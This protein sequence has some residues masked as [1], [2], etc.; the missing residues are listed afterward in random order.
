MLA[1]KP[2]GKWRFCIDYRKLNAITKSISWPIPNIKQ[3]LLRIGRQNAT[4]FGI[5]DL[6]S[7]YHQ[8]VMTKQSRKYTAFTTP[9][10]IY[11]F[12]R[13]PFGL[14]GSPA[15]FQ[16]TMMTVVLKGM[17]GTICEVYLDDILVYSR[18][19]EE[20]LEKLRAILTRFRQYNIKA[21]PAKTRLGLEEIEYLG[22]TINKR[23]V[24][25]STAKKH[26]VLLTPLPTT[27]KQLKQFLGLAN[28]FRDHVRNHSLTVKP[29]NE[30]LR[31]YERHRKIQWT[32]EAQ[33][34]FEQI[35]HDIGH[36]PMLYFVDDTSPIFLHTDASDFGVGGY[37]FQRTPEGDKPI[38]FCC[39]SLTQLQS[40]VWPPTEKEA[41]G[42]VFSLR[43]FHHYLGGVNFTIRTDHRNLTFIES[44]SSARV[45]RWKIEMQEYD[46]QVE[47]IKGED[48]F[49]ADILS[50]QDFV[51]KPVKSPTKQL[52][53]LTAPE[54]IPR[55]R[56]TLISAVHNTVMGH[57][58]IERTIK[59]LLRQ[60]QYWPRLRSHVQSFV[61]LCPCCQKMSQLK[62]PIQVLR[63]TLAKYEPMERINVDTVGPLPEDTHGM[64][65][66]LVIIDCFTRWVQLYPIA[67]TSAKET[68]PC[69]LH[70]VSNYSTPA[71]M[72]SDNGAQ[73]VNEIIFEL[74]NL[75]VMDQQLTLA[76]SHEE[77]GIVE[78]AN[79]TMMTHL[80]N[81]I[82]D[83]NTLH[84]WSENFR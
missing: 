37:L 33:V 51:D 58:G 56:Y 44:E 20:F 7:G 43:K 55:S 41:C 4:I 30:I 47:Y 61:R 27:E 65:Y 42:I 66:V 21:N 39:A 18:N 53:T 83:T 80:R 67:S 84:N 11:E 59:L 64:K 25:F 12:T 71:E 15:F 78:R 40:D 28:Y 29:L 6:T 52:L 72:L 48:N 46:F 26:A 45:R 14:K 34:A 63:Y 22:H 3:T 62:T 54:L 8:V 70:W 79:K 2:E 60:G 5:I 1:P 75:M 76:Y 73:F 17:M 74:S 9:Q 16:R 69:I 19:Q 13:V 32:P 10:G 77:N 68:A 31:R 82:F 57:H 24:D 49:V 36:C 23:G 38:A 35:R 50:R 81:I